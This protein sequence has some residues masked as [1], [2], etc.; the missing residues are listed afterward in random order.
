VVLEHLDIRIRPGEQAQFEPALEHG[1]RD[2]IARAP[3]MLGWEIHKGVESPERYVVLIRWE[4]IEAHLVGYRESPLSSEF[5]AIVMPF[6]AQPPA[7]EHVTLLKR[8]AEKV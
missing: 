6:F 5:R 8:S 2:V 7:M 4:S 3:G 1:L